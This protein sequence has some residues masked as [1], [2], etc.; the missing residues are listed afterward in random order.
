V[1]KI[2]W[3]DHTINPGIYGCSPAPEHPG[4]DHCYAQKMAERIAAMRVAR[5]HDFDRGCNGG[6][7]DY[8]GDVTTGGKW[9][10]DVVVD[11]DAIPRA[12]A[13]LP[14]IKPAR[15]FVTSMGDLF[16]PDVPWEFISR[17][18][19]EMAARPHLAFQVL[20][21]RPDN[22]VRVLGHLAGFV[23][24]S[25]SLPSNVWI[26]ASVSDQTTAERL[27]PYLLQVPSSGRFLSVEPLVGPVLLPLRYDRAGRNLTDLPGLWDE[28]DDV[29]D[30]VIVGCESGPNRRPMRLSWASSIVDQC[31]DASV[32]VF[33]KQLPYIDVTDERRTGI[34]SDN[35]SPQWPPW[36]VRALPEEV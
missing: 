22:A 20:T 6:G 19:V 35:Q 2:Q 8:Y 15:V 14:K 23:G 31:R 32:A 26:G 5:G 28:S 13:K 9:T 7:A 25:A 30:W 21:K 17:V 3:T 36:A 11:F 18:I 24:E 10:G 34:L 33:V 12:F 29:I 27:V 4:C 16:H 1:T